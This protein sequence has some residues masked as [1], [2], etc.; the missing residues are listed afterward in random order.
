M[1]LQVTQRQ[2]FPRSDSLVSILMATST[3]ACRDIKPAKGP[4]PLIL[5][6]T[7]IGDFQQESTVL[8][9][10]LASHGYIVA[11]VPQ[12][13]PDINHFNL[14]Y[15]LEGLSLQVQDAAFALSKLVHL[16]YVDE[17]RIGTIGHS[18][19][20]LVAWQ[21][22]SIN[23]NIKVMVS[24]D[25]SINRKNGHEVLRAAA[26]DAATMRIPV[27]N[28]YTLNQGERDLSIVDAASHAHRYHVVLKNASHYDFQNWA[29]YAALTHTTDSRTESLRSS[30]TGRDIY[31][32]IVR[33]TR[34]FLDG[35]LK[36]D[37]ATLAY[38]SGESY[39]PYI[40]EGL[41]EFRFQPGSDA[42]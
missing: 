41:V 10:Y 39:P 1:F 14:P 34:A 30:E 3:A 40:P 17:D 23:S 15:S 19:G 29:L 27:L 12:F 37:T 35:W 20:G 25:G 13:G 32:S 16:P 6:A 26:W 36:N 24:L 8:W 2:F 38:V 11:V 18:Y 9:E 42:Q 22:A 31:L 7:G 33:L 4:F 28:M 5:Y 21:L